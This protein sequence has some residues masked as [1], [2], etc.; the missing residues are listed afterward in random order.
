MTV[1][2]QT[3]GA[4]PDV[5]EQMCEDAVRCREVESALVRRACGYTVPVRKTFKLRRIEYDSQ[6]GKKLSESEALEVG[7]DEEHIPADV[8]V[9][10]YYL[11]NRDPARWREHPAIEDDVTPDGMIAFPSMAETTGRPETDT[12]RNEDAPMAVEEQYD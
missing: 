10:A 9:C 1:A 3:E 8:R 11:N 7:V 2:V 12:S 6:T 4:L 5:E